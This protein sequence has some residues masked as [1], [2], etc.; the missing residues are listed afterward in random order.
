MKTDLTKQYKDRDG[1]IFYIRPVEPTDKT[2]IA[3]GFKNLRP[4]SIRQRFQV[5]K[6]GFSE[7]E[8]KYLTEID[9]QNHMAFCAFYEDEGEIIPIGIIRAIKDSTKSNRL[10]VA[11]TIAD[12]FQK[13]GIGMYLMEALENWAIPLGYQSFMGELHNSNEKMIKLLEKFASKRDKLIVTHVGYGFM[14]FE[15]PLKK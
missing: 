8:L 12:P 14:Y 15:V 9:Q 3:Q 10:E 5:G 7:D 1:R 11:I 2:Y 6:T 13:K 4:E